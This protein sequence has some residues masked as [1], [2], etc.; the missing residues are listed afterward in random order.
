MLRLD[1]KEITPISGKVTCATTLF[2]QNFDEQLIQRQ[3]GHQ[4]SAVRVYKQPSQAQDK[5]VSDALQPP[6]S[7]ARSI[8]QCFKGEKESET[9]SIAGAN[10]QTTGNRVPLINIY[11]SFSNREQ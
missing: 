2:N 1:F 8:P 6:T 4:S 7:S 11:F 9:S 3:A 10:L 5:E